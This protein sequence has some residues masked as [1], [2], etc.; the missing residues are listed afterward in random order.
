MSSKKT[1]VM[2]IGN[3][4]LSDEGIGIHILEELKLQSPTSDNIEYIDG[5]TLS[6]TLAGPIESADNLIVIDAA[7][8]KSK[9]GTV[10]VFEADAM[11]DYITN[12]NKKSVHEVGLADLLSISLLNEQL[13]KNR[14]LVG[15]QPKNIDWGNEPTPEVSASISDAVAEVQN[16]VTRWQ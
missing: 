14:A 4:L 3:T 2:G 1:L 16:L 9:P 15:I 11:D 6:F 7:E 13:P 8:L 5:G 10:K 12:G